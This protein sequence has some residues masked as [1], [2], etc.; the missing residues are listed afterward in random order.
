MPTFQLHKNQVVN[1]CSCWPTVHPDRSLRW[2]SG[3]GILWSGKTGL[4]T[5]LFLSGESFMNP[6]YYIFPY[7]GKYCNHWLKCLFLMTSSDLLLKCVLCLVV[8]IPPSKSYIYT[9]PPTPATHPFGT[10]SELSERLS[11]GYNLHFVSNKNSHFFPRLTI[12]FCWN[13]F[14]CLKISQKFVKYQ[15]SWSIKILVTVLPSLIFYI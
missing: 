2:R 4:Q 1:H 12:N 9:C 5:V 11:P 13:L 6:G 14:K 3:W 10:F 8:C 7:L 15:E